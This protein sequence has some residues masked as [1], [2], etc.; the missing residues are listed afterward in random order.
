MSHVP[1]KESTTSTVPETDDA[2]LSNALKG[3]KLQRAMDM[4][5]PPVTP[6]AQIRRNNTP[7]QVLPGRI[8]DMPILGDG[9]HDCTGGSSQPK[10]SCPT[11]KKK[12]KNVASKKSKKCK[13]A[14]GKK[15]KCL[16]STT[17]K[18][19]TD[20]EVMKT[21]PALASAVA[22]PEGKPPVATPGSVDTAAYVPCPQTSRPIRKEDA[23]AAMALVKKEQKETPRLPGLQATTPTSVRMAK[24]VDQSQ[25]ENLARAATQE[26]EPS[27][28][29]NG[30]EYYPSP[31]YAATEEGELGSDYDEFLN[32][33]DDDKNDAQPPVSRESDQVSPAE[34]TKTSSTQK[35]KGKKE[36]TPLQKAMHA[37]YMK[38]SRSI[39]SS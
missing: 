17:T 23:P 30:T 25:E 24:A 12:V 9:G 1:G 16:K 28:Q 20:A 21:E 18:A 6:P 37:R 10:A 3:L 26:L 11:A 7:R 27:D 38:F 32:S 29:T 22:A 31:T 13:K 39:R 19:T 2:A 34:T 15:G 14:P 5:S 35:K 4:E 8:G 33:L 36:K